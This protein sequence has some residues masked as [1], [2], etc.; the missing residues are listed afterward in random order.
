MAK[1]TKPTRRANEDI[2]YRGFVRVI[3][4]GEEPEIMD[5]FYARK[6]ANEMGL[7]LVE[8]NM[9]VNPAIVKICDYGKMMYEEKKKAK[10][11]K[12]NAAP[13]I[14]EIQ[15]TANIAEHDLETKAKAVSKFIENGSKVRVV[16]KL[17]GRELN[18]KS[19]NCRSIYSFLEM[20]SDFAQAETL[21]KEEGNKFIVV[22]KRKK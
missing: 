15:L 8:I 6:K 11:E 12:S 2:K 4:E 21:P 16:L 7:D 17:K 10:R 1:D 9:N 19:V 13:E 18:N 5:I 14:K 22:L 3:V 20:V